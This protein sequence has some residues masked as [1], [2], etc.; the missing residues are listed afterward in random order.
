MD[1]QD[2]RDEVARAGTDEGRRFD[3]ELRERLVAAARELSRRG[4]R[5]VEIAESLG[6]SASTVT[7]YLRLEGATEDVGD[8]V[9]VEVVHDF[10]SGS[11]PPSKSVT[12]PGGFRVEGL[13][14][15]EVVSLLEA[16]S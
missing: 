6:I 3:P 2:L 12:T 15:D 16:L 1:T 7:R 10:R 8:A 9:M 14:L 4:M 11:L 5:R 13:A